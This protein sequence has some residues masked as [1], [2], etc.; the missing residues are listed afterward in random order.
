MLNSLSKTCSASAVL[1]MRE[2]VSMTDGPAQK[3]ETEH[4][5]VVSC[6]LSWPPLLCPLTLSL[7]RNRSEYF[8]IFLFPL[9]SDLSLQIDFH[10][11]SRAASES[12]PL[13]CLCV[14][15]SPESTITNVT[16]FLT[17]GAFCF[18]RLKGNHFT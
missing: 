1:Q 15:R 4:R 3:E 5:E 2:A 13:C 17:Q 16:G 12:S 9:F 14:L 18:I 6:L 8:S 11:V 10:S 7:H